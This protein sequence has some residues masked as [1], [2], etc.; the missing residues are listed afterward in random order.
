MKYP[1]IEELRDVLSVPFEDVP[2]WLDENQPTIT[3]AIARYR[4]QKGI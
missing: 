3:L 4:L 2:M 1:S